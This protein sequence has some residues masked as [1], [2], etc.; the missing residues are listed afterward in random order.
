MA[1]KRGPDG[2]TLVAAGEVIEVP[3]P[4]PVQSVDPTGAGDAFDGV[5]VAALAAGSPIEE[6]LQRAVA[7]GSRVAA[8]GEPW[9]RP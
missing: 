1:V 5:L 9:P 8:S 2:A 7:A 3:A 4:A 6:A